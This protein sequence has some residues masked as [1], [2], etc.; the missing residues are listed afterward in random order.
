M[1]SNELQPAKADE[2]PPKRTSA[3][4][5]AHHPGNSHHSLTAPE[6]SKLEQASNQQEPSDQEEFSDQENSSDELDLVAWQGPWS[7]HS[8]GLVALVLVCHGYPLHRAQF[9]LEP[10]LELNVHYVQ[11]ALEFT[12]GCC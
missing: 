7:L 11:Y 10:E 12:L 4:I 3:P 6:E 9:P 8:Q 5:D 1:T 2:R